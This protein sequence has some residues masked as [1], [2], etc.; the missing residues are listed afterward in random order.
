MNMQSVIRTTDRRIGLAINYP[1]GNGDLFVAFIEEFHPGATLLHVKDA[2]G[3][4]KDIVCESDGS[5]YMN[6]Q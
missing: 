5:T 4:R 3:N 1:K 6:R 2:K